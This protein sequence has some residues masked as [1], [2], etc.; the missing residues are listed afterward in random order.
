VYPIRL[1]LLQ[2][3]PECACSP[4]TKKSAEGPAAWPLLLVHGNAGHY[5]AAAY[6][7]HKVGMKGHTIIITGSAGQMVGARMRRGLIYVLGDSGDATNQSSEVFIKST[8]PILVPFFPRHRTAF[9]R[10]MC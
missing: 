2:M 1:L 5:T 9:Q 4:E 10:W 3:Q 8:P 7:G 6:R